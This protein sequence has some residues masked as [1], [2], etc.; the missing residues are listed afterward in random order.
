LPKLNYAFKSNNITEAYNYH[1]MR[2]V[3]TIAILLISMA[4]SSCMIA[5]TYDYKPKQDYGYKKEQ[6]PISILN[7]YMS[8]YN[9]KGSSK[10]SVTIWIAKT[11]NDKIQIDYSKPNLV[12]ENA[13]QASTK[14]GGFDIRTLGTNHS[15]AMEMKH[16]LEDVPE[17]L[18]ILKDGQYFSINFEITFTEKMKVPRSIKDVTLVDSIG[19]SVNGQKKLFVTEM[20]HK[21]HRYLT[22]RSYLYSS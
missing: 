8:F 1:T 12:F 13:K 18:R 2:R 3:L 20:H 11:T 7:S 6:A 9:Y 14:L 17:Q 22:F 21:R 5:S 4:L 19:Y 10:A 15:V 16:S